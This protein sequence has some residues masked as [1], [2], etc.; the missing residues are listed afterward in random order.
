MLF[1][2]YFLT[3]KRENTAVP[4]ESRVKVVKLGR[5]LNS[6]TQIE[7]GGGTA[8][9]LWDAFVHK[10]A[11]IDWHPPQYQS[12]ETMFSAIALSNSGS[13]ETWRSSCLHLHLIVPWDIRDCEWHLISPFCGFHCPLHLGLHKLFKLD[14]YLLYP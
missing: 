11:W 13:R 4:T 2:W 1:F 8:T 12:L 5:Y 14:F 6:R 9:F 3:C 10:V 7:A